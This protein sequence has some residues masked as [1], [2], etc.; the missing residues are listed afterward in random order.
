MSSFFVDHYKSKSND[1]KDM[2][3]VSVSQNLV[4]EI[5]SSKDAFNELK[6]EYINDYEAVQTA[7]SDFQSKITVLNQYKKA[8]LKNDLEKIETVLME[9][10]TFLEPLLPSQKEKIN[11]FRTLERLNFQQFEKSE[12]SLTDDNLLPSFNEHFDRAFTDKSV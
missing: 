8:L 7:L 2:S 5:T 9:N 10:K 11:F 4:E 6:Y 3:D 1:G 12:N